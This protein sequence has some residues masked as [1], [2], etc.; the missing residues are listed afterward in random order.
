VTIEEMDAA[1]GDA[2]VERFCRA[3]GRRRWAGWR[4]IASSVCWLAIIS[5]RFAE[6]AIAPRNAWVHCSRGAE[7][8]RDYR[9]A[10]IAF[11]WRE[12]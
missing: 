3:V 5:R 4:R 6:C 12:A 7:P 11:C 2:A 10:A 1:I 9:S 8:G